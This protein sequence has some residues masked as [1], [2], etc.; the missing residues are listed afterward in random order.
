[1]K[2][3]I[4]GASGFVGQSLFSGLSLLGNNVVGTYFHYRWRSFKDGC[5]VEKILAVWFF[6]NPD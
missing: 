5:K 6:K 3:I 2:I 1:M 4:I